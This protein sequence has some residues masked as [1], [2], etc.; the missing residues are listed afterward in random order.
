MLKPQPR[1]ARAI[2]Q[3]L[4]CLKQVLSLSIRGRAVTAS[5]NG[6]D[7]L[8]GKSPQCRVTPE[9]RDRGQ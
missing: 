2:W 8:R 4:H 1:K 7:H 6:T 3:K 9:G 5:E